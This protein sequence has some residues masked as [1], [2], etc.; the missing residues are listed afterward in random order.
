MRL[1]DVSY[2]MPG[3]L[4]LAFRHP[5]LA[6]CIAKDVGMRPSLRPL[7]VELQNAQ[8]GQPQP[9]SF[10]EPISQYSVFTGL[11]VTV[12]P[13]NDAPGNPMKYINDAA[14]SLVTGVTFDMTVQSRSGDNY[15]PVPEEVPVQVLPAAF[16]AA[17]WTWRMLRPENVKAR[18]TVQSALNASP[19]TI[20]VVFTFMV[21][22]TEGDVY[23]NMTGDRARAELAQTNAYKLAMGQLIAA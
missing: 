11:S 2:P 8:I 1:V 5:Q 12:D 9:T 19:F 18:F 23:L 22:A 6:L 17:A 13:T 16:S 10:A 15:S 21:V 3:L 4:D 14:Q 20:W 7:A